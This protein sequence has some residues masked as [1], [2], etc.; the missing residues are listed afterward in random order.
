MASR[1]RIKAILASQGMTIKSL[2]EKMGCTAQSLGMQIGDNATPNVSSLEKIAAALNVPVSS[3][4]ADSVHPSQA[5]VICP[6]C[7]GRIDITTGAAK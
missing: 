5:T 6:Y 1:F 2:A 7:G 3:L 4:F